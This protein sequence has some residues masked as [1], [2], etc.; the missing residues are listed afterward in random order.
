[1]QSGRRPVGVSAARGPDRPRSGFIIQI[2]RPG[3]TLRMDDVET[4]LAG[5][6]VEL[7]PSYGPIL[8]NPG[9]GRF[10]VRGRGDAT[11]RERAAAIPGVTLFVDA[12]IKPMG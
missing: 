10:V 8:V 12:R 2:E 9:L 5:T 11:A 4:L 1:A 3:Q 7:D 6:G